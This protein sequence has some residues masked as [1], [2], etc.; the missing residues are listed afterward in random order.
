MQLFARHGLRAFDL[1]R[2][3]VWD[4]PRVE[5]WY[6]QNTLLLASQKALE[7]NLTLQHACDTSFTSPLAVVHPRAFVSVMERI[8]QAPR[9]VVRRMRNL[10]SYE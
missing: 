3:R 9:R 10:L 4:D 8:D 6:A 2:P 5:V 1:I 7:T